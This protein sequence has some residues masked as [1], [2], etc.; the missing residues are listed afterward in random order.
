LLYLAFLAPHI[1]VLVLL[2]HGVE[3]GSITVTDLTEQIHMKK[4]VK[5]ITIPLLGGLFAWWFIRRLD[6]RM[7][8][9]HLGEAQIWPLVL[10][11]LIVNLTMLSRSL[12]WQVLLAPSARV[13]LRNLLAATS[14]GFGALFVIGRTGEIVRP[15]MLSIHEKLRPSLTFASIFIERIFDTATIILLFSI[16]L[17]FFKFPA[18]SPVDSSTIRLFRLVGLM[19]TLGIL[20]IVALLTLLRLRA[21]PTIKLLETR[22]LPLSPRLL[23]PIINFV[24][25]LTEGLSV[26]TN[27]RELSAT[28]LHTIILWSLIFASGW[29]TFAAFDLHFSLSELIFMTGFGVVGSL[30]PTPGGSAGAYHAVAAR[31]V[32]LLGVEPNLAASAVIVGHLIGFVPPFLMGLYFIVRD[33]IHLTQIRDIL[34]REGDPHIID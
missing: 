34:T 18:A 12:R 19:T 1:V 3:A 20:T 4:Y 6:W 27:I 13:S 31:S 8:G 5:T 14:I 25:H 15:A 33:E 22:V 17:L 2:K 16:N 28:I 30:I 10:A 32:E 11:A 21:E 24:Q 26:L 9:L 23:R 7:V 29:I